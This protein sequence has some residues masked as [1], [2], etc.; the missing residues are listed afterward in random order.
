MADGN[1]IILDGTWMSTGWRDVLPQQSTALHMLIATATD[2]DFAGSLDDLVSGFGEGWF[3]YFTGGLDCPIRWI[4]PEDEGERE[5]QVAGRRARRY[6]VNAFRAT[7]RRLPR[8]V[9]EL[10]TTMAHLGIV[11]VDTSV[12]RWRTVQ[13]PPLPEEI[14]PMPRSFRVAQDRRRWEEM[15][16]ETALHIAQV[17]AAWS[18]DGEA[19]STSI[20][21]LEGATGMPEV[22]VRAGLEVLAR[23]D[24]ATLHLPSGEVGDPERIPRNVLF[25]VELDRAACVPDFGW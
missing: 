6:C 22:A 11:E 24:A 5:D 15:N 1:D 23:Y 3:D 20:D 14:L 12:P 2:R 8:T 16:G 7:G 21:D 19:V 13:W 25:T 17:V 18:P 9:R 10:A 4:H